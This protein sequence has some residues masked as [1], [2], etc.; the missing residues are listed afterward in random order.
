MTKNALN[1]DR[2][3]GDNL[4][5]FKS[6]VREDIPYFAAVGHFIVKYAAAES[7]IHL[8]VRS[9]SGLDEHKAR[10]IFSGQRVQDLTRYIK[11]L[12]RLNKSPPNIVDEINSCI[13]Q[14]DVI[15]EKR[16]YL[17]H[18]TV[19]Y[20][21]AAI[22]VSNVIT[23]RSLHNIEE[24]KFSISDLLDMAEDCARIFIRLYLAC[25]QHDDIPSEMEDWLRAP[26]KYIPEQPKPHNSQSPK[27]R[28]GRQRRPLSSQG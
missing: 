18:R 28:K 11:A 6:S 15:G 22:H 13:N 26:W 25:G 10:E 21:D 17:F 7:G 3:P 1:D 8:V 19:E 27:N 12:L 4:A 24:S 20:R 23:A 5:S 2:S 14:L 9:L 16:N